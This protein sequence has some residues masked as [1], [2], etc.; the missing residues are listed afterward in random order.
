VSAT[1]A[2][3]A[4]DG[5]TL[6]GR[7][8]DLAVLLHRRDEA[9]AGRPRVVVLEGRAGIGKSALIGALVAASP[10]FQVVRASGDAAEAELAYGVLDQLARTAGTTGPELVGAGRHDAIG[11]GLGM[12][13]LLGRLQDDGP[14]LLIVDDA[15][16]ADHAS[17]HALLF[18]LRRLVADAVLAVLAVRDED[19]ER[20]PAG[21]GR[22]ADGGHGMR[23]R[24]AALPPEALQE[25]A[26][27]RGVPLS[28]RAARRLHAHTLGCPAT[29]AALL[30]ELPAAAWQDGRPLP[31]PRA[32]AAGVEARLAGCEPTARALV[33]AAAVLGDAVPLATVAALAG[34]GD[35]FPALEE[36]IGAG[37]LALS[38]PGSGGD[39]TFPYPPIRAAVYD[40]LGAARRA[41]LHAA[42]AGASGDAAAALR[43]RVA[44][45][46]GADATLAAALD[47]QAARDAAR[48]AW[49]SVGEA[50]LAAA[51]LSPDAAD[52][53]R[54]LFDAADAFVYAGDLARAQAL[55]DDLA[56]QPGGPGR[57]AVLGHVAQFAAP[58]EAE[59]LLRR[60]WSRCDER[61]DPAIAARVARALAM[62][63]MLR[64]DGDETVAWAARA[65]DLAGA[66]GDNGVG[67]LA[68][69]VLA[70]GR[71]L[72]GRY[73][74]AEEVLRS[75]RA[76]V[77]ADNG[78]PLDALLAWFRLGRDDV[79]GARGILAAVAPDA[80]GLGSY[81][82]AALTHATRARVA[83][84]AGAWDDAA[85]SGARA[86]AIVR[87]FEYISVRAVA[88]WAAVLVP[89]ARGEWETADALA[90]AAAAV[91]Q[92][93][94]EAHT[95]G[96]LTIAIVAAARQQHD[97]VLRALG[98]VACA[99]PRNGID[100]PAMWPWPELYAE[101]LVGTGQLDAAA[102]FLP[103][104]EALA[105]ERG[106]RTAQLRLARV[107]GRLE[108]A[109]GNAE[110][111][112]T[113]FR[114]ALELA[115][116]LALPFDRALSQLAYGQFLRR[117][118]HRRAAADMLRAA[119]AAF[120][121]LGAV[122]YV[123]RGARELEACG[124]APAKRSAMDR[125]DLTP[126]ERSVAGLVSTGLTNREVASELVLSVK[127][128]EV[129]L[130]R[131]YSKLGVKS[132]G[133]LAGVDF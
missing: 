117:Q 126:Q 132:R 127:T 31:A 99:R 18:A 59:S 73:D 120:T 93:P 68:A 15:Q 29:S 20:L 107:R 74:Q 8:A 26:L 84:H 111:A 88:R 17:L 45:S 71:M 66:V 89:A 131:I 94:Q 80:A 109:Q 1:A 2:G 64:L 133:E 39:V 46:P 40:G 82:I 32:Y 105:V 33:E 3:T 123:E 95:I 4:T 57:D 19:A 81:D 49:S 28:A 103:A 50:L 27:T 125:E 87:E 116:A 102:A 16:W 51:R 56:A 43:H 85:A 79:V 35:P 48:G 5:T 58:H 9:R 70:L 22:L 24:L 52:R 110:P 90:A 42:A 118:G 41:A 130:T 108:A 69:A 129:H 86:A 92:S 13:Q 97:E 114:A 121:A 63:S 60:A 55:A 96:G 62:Q 37:L 34:V 104:H 76:G 53:A 115:E 75:A 14:V 47:D 30:E 44:A 61:A 112:E 119:Q 78:L 10:G 122:P 54:R 38:A 77:P 25:L 124:L 72:Q 91:P 106:V 128:V 11:A 67:S 101:A 23:L 100:E 7:D 6:A 113:A 83:F 12:L 21:I 65:R 36:A 98:P